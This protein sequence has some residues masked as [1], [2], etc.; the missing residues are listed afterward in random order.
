MSFLVEIDENAYPTDALDKFSASPSF[1]LED[2][3]A[4]MWMSQL[5]YE[6]AHPD[7]VERILDRWTLDRKAFAS[8]NPTARLPPNSA[9]FVAAAGRYLSSC[10]RQRHR[11]DGSAHDTGW[12]SACWSLFTGCERR[13]FRCPNCAPADQSEQSRYHQKCVAFRA[14]YNLLLCIG[15]PNSDCWSTAPRPALNPVAADGA[16][17]RPGELFSSTIGPAQIGAS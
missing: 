1:A 4:M 17:S 15:A 5:A 8:N 10:S 13:S 12:I 9:C 11:S 7:K 2:A 16:R 3:R 6:T 14:R